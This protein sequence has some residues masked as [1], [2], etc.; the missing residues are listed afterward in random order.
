MHA[1]LG[2]G[3]AARSGVAGLFNTRHTVPHVLLLG[4]LAVF[5]QC[6]AG[7]A[8][9]AFQAQRWELSVLS[10]PGSARQLKPG[11][12]AQNIFLGQPGSFFSF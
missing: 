8:H 11:M 2:E 4:V 10:S 12:T 3:K 9:A 1:S 5:V 6:R 7:T